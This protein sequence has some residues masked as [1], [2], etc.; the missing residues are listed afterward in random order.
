[1]SDKI[2]VSVNI[3]KDK[4]KEKLAQVSISSSLLNRNAKKSEPVKKEPKT[5]VSVKIAIKEEENFLEETV[6]FP[7]VLKRDPDYSC[8]IVFLKPEKEIYSV[9][10]YMVEKYLGLYVHKSNYYFSNENRSKAVSCYEE[11]LN[12]VKDLKGDSIQN[13]L[14]QSE[15]PH[16]LRRA[17]RQKD[18]GNL[19]PKVNQ[20]ATYLNPSNTENPKEGGSSN[21]LYIPKRNSIS[22]SLEIEKK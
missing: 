1:M 21:I 12:T 2:K 22:D 19:T 13:G 20:T 11:V 7:S 14:K 15:I 3:K 18:F 9:S 8:Y 17:L 6:N 4:S 5:K 10:V 16:I